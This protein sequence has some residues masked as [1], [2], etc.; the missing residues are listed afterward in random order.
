MSDSAFAVNQDEFA[1]G[2]TLAGEVVVRLNREMPFRGV[3]LMQG[4]GKMH[5]L[6]GLVSSAKGLFVWFSGRSRCVLMLA[7][8]LWLPPLAGAA[9]GAGRYLQRPPGWFLSPEGLKITANVLS[10]Q[11]AEG[12]WPKNLDTTRQPYRG[13]PRRITGTFDNGATTDELRFLAGAFRASHDDRCKQAIFKGLDHI[14]KAQY[15]TGGWPQYYPPSRQY[16]RRITFNDGAMVR[17]LEFLREA[18]T[19]PAFDFLDPE[20]RQAAQAAF[21]RGIQC[22]LKCQVRVEGKLTVWCA[23]H[24]ELTLEPR[25]GRTYELPSLSGS[26]SAGIL[27]L[28]MSFPKPSPEIRAAIRAGA[29]WFAAAR[30][31][32]IRI[33]KVNGERVVVRDPNA[34][35]LWARFYDLENGRPV[36]SDRDGI[37]KY[38][39]M[40]IGRERRNGYA[41]YGDW[42]NRVATDYARWQ[43]LPV[44]PSGP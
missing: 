27:R 28:L 35:P 11:S 33:Q 10:W 39:F 43:R 7:G 37:K 22:I 23:Q 13:N 20:R 9:T 36:F 44:S 26:E 34:P 30:V 5:C 3:R 1:P 24:D 12:S 6:A 25:G 8:V 32:G 17:L 4:S 38:D 16:H 40:Q 29:E 14:L 31:T 2:D 18:A 15:P 21:D 19:P 41:W 42:G